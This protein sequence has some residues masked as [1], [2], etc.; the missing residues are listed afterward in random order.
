MEQ[1]FFFFF[2]LYLFSRITSALDFF[3][4][5][6]QEQH[7]F[8]IVAGLLSV[9]RSFS[10]FFSP[11]NQDLDLISFWD[12]SILRSIWLDF[13][14]LIPSLCKGYWVSEGKVFRNLKGGA[15]GWWTDKLNKCM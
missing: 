1:F 5:S 4:Y 12:T 2:P 14:L 9:S 10:F 7:K 3:Y 13:V 8:I 11:A 15:T 6:P